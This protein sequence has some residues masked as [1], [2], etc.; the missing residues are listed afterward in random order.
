MD[1]VFFFPLKYVARRLDIYQAAYDT[2]FNNL[3]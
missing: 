3:G 2:K 1:F